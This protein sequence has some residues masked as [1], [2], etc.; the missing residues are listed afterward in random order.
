MET[1]VSGNAVFSLA[2]TLQDLGGRFASKLD[3]VLMA[4]IVLVIF[5]LIAKLVR[6]IIRN[7]APRVKADTSAMFLVA[8]LAYAT[9]IV[10]GTTVA[11]N[12]SGVNWTALA[13]GL[14]LTG[15][16]LGFALKDAISN[17]ISGVLIL[18][19]RPFKIG[20]RVKAGNVVGVVKDIRVRDTVIIDEGGLKTIVP[21][22]NVF[23]NIIVNYTESDIREES[24]AE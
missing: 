15:F 21:N 4:I 23:A 5:W 10:V 19:Y 3:D 1:D 7:A 14:G 9:L 12:A 8:R 11:L 16:A 18:F 17:F 2:A 13:A 6:R 24:K 20:D 22:S